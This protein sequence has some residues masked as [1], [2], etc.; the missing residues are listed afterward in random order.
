MCATEHLLHVLDKKWDSAHFAVLGEMSENT[1]NIICNAAN[2]CYPAT[3]D[4]HIHPGDSSVN[5]CICLQMFKAQSGCFVNIDVTMRESY[6]LFLWDSDLN[7][8]FSLFSVNVKTFSAIS[9]YQ[10]FSLSLRG[11]FVVPTRPHLTI[12]S[13]DLQKVCFSS[14]CSTCA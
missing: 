4:M 3:G 8:P 11:E 6:W 1:F 5:A 12:R 7:A 13:D 9:S 2:N 10:A 14:S